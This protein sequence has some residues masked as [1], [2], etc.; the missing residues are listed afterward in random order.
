MMIFDFRFADG[1]VVS[2]S[3]ANVLDFSGATSVPGPTESLLG[4]LPA[5]VRVD[6]GQSASTNAPG[7]E[8]SEREW[9]ARVVFRTTGVPNSRQNLFESNKVPFAIF[10][11]TH[12]AGGH[13][14]KV[15][16]SAG[17][18]TYGW[19]SV[20]SRFAR[21]TVLADDWMTVDVFYSGDT[22]IL[23][24]DGATVDVQSFPNPDLV[25]MTGDAFFAGSWVDGVR[26]RFRGEIAA[27]QLLNSVPDD[28]AAAVAAA[29]RSPQW[30]IS[31]KR[32][33]IESSFNLGDETGPVGF[34]GAALAYVQP[35]E[36]GLVMYND[37][38]GAAF[39]MH[40]Q[41]WNRYVAMPNKADIGYLVSDEVASTR[42]G[43][44]KSLFSKGGIYWSGQTGAHPVL[45]RI[46]LS[47]ED[48]G[49]AG[50]F[51]L[52][53]AAEAPLPGGKVQ[54]FEG[55]EFYHRDGN[56][57][58][59]EVHG[60]ILHRYK[61]TGGAGTW[62]FPTSNETNV[63]GRGTPGSPGAP[64]GRMSTFEGC[65]FY[66]TAGTGAFEVHGDIKVKYDAL[67]G[68]AGEL[69]F[70]TSDESDIPGISG[71]GRI[72]SFVNGAL[73]WYGSFAS[74]IVAR[75][76]K[77]FVG[78]MS[79]NE[80]EG[81]GMGQNDLYCFIRA[82]DGGQT[83]NK[84]HPGDGD[85]GGNNTR[86]LNLTIP[87]VFRPNSIGYLVSFHLKAMDAD[88]GN[89]DHL[90][91]I[92]R[93]LNAA[94]GWG[95][96][97]NNGIFNDSFANVNSLK[98]SV[99]PEVDIASLS[100]PQKW[101]G[102]SNAGTAV[103]TYP[104]YARAFRD[105]DS[106]SEWWDLSDWL[107]R[108]FYELAVKKLASKGNCFGMSTEGIY[109][110]KGRSVFGMPLDR[111]NNFGQLEQ[112]FNIRHCYQVGASAVW[113][114]AGQFL[115][116]NTRDPKDVFDASRA[117][118]DRGENPVICVAQNWD[119]SG[120]PHCILPVGWRKSGSAWTMDILDPNA[121]GAM[122][123]LTV[124]ANANTFRY[125]GSST[126][127]GG[128][129]TGG[130]FHYMPFSVLCERPRTPIWDAI[131]LLLAGTIIIFG[132]DADTQSITDASGANLD[133]FSPAA[134]ERLR[135]SRNLNGYFVDYKGISGEAVQGGMLLR[136]AP[137]RR[138]LGTFDA[139][140]AAHASIAELV[141][142]RNAELAGL[143]RAVDGLEP[144]LRRLVMNRQSATVL[145]DES[146]QAR[147]GPAF[148]DML[149]GL[150]AAN[151][152]G[153]YDHKLVGKRNGTLDYLVRVA[154]NTFR[155]ETRIG[156]RETVALTARDLDSSLQQLSLT[157]PTDR[158]IQLTHQA[159]L[160]GGKDFVQMKLS[161]VPAKANAPL[162]FSV[163]PGMGGA[164]VVGIADGPNVRLE[165]ESRVGGRLTKRTY[166]LPTEAG[167]RVEIGPAIDQGDLLFSRIDQ[168]FGPQRDLRVLRPQP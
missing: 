23:L 125:Q 106:E 81:F 36:R 86:E 91:T 65:T 93:V 75:P 160:G 22:L 35:F 111:F 38:V 84:R 139:S 145:A 47:Y 105:V 72:N 146:M 32:L 20:D 164:D 12:S 151:T 30:F 107:E 62:G 154:L 103:V 5:A 92:D 113:W 7:V 140:V 131:L 57:V 33:E 130:R 9:T 144:R 94:N 134:T 49:E 90:G 124:D 97:N 8:I 120:A 29:R 11:D 122:R 44:R 168:P 67:G 13:Q 54:V 150:R 71:P 118:F 58:A 85:W 112:E 48:L 18:S 15:V 127:Q 55:A 95:L 121:P 60:E 141:G 142:S 149:R 128:D 143:R 46:W 129:G 114:F 69:G 51:G 53:R 64:I 83:Y 87:N 104:N 89:D 162:Q 138:L 135:R 2:S 56:P 63:I 68:P 61:L 31:R 6:G 42:A 79:T 156:L 159:R 52:P 59:F 119:F 98:W 40:G 158:T 78:R 43:A 115:S 133:A 110:R 14:F 25:N 4:A 153:A 21:T 28:I 39:E 100:E 19:R 109:A 155:V 16:A 27:I 165:L 88:P 10:V 45:G 108:A 66:W 157:A 77:I 1:Q 123:T 3:G 161:G 41:I 126:Y 24:I 101:W 99:K 117:A 167:L 102:A 147:L 73:C 70:P 148:V 132:D 152:D 116:G 163:R 34:D 26:N 137:K 50:A 74:I 82:S 80:N 136:T 17:T 76:F 166:A 37:G 96:R